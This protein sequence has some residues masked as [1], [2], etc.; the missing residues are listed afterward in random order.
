MSAPVHFFAL[1]V[2]VLFSNV[3]H[4]AVGAHRLVP[5]GRCSLFAVQAG[6]A[7]AASGSQTTIAVGSVGVA[8][9]TSITGNI[10]LLDGAVEANSPAAINCAGDELIAY[11]AAKD[12]YCPANQTLSD[13][14]LGG[15]TF[16]PGVYCAGNFLISAGI[17]TLDGQNRSNSQWLFQA[18]TSLETATATSFIL[19][20]GAQAQNVF[21][22]IGSSASI[23]YSSSFV[24][25][26]LAYASVS[27][28]TDASIHGRVFAQAAVTFAGG[29]SITRPPLPERFVF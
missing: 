22:Q 10:V 20:N 3:A 19:Q 26:I 9:G 6:A 29:D 16:Y 28:D 21:W 13:P 23:G 8:P 27:L 5:L 4:M 1:L 7:V 18:A 24:G 2:G 15:L 11:D 14:D 25:T 17:V 12:A